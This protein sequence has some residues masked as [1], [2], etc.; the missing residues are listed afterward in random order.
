M[1][2]EQ[3]E[4]IES[5]TLGIASGV[6]VAYPPSAPIVAMVK[7]ALNY[8][9]EHGYTFG[10]PVEISAEHAAA[11]AAGIA[12]MKSSAVTSFQ[13]SHKDKLPSESK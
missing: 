13:E 12:A 2:K 10:I 8:F 1:T 5:I 9:M 11:I 6:A 7:T 3:I 4:S